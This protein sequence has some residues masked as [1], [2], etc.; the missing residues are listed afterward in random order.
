L[1]IPFISARWSTACEYMGLAAAMAII[2]RLPIRRLMAI[3][4]LF[5]SLRKTKLSIAA[6]PFLIHD[7]C[8]T[9]GQTVADPVCLQIVGSNG[10]IALFD[11]I[12]LQDVDR[13]AK[14]MALAVE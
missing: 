6:T 4:F 2:S 10:D 13:M 9:F 7:Q 3:H 5:R 11:H 12:I 14:A 1:P 8:L